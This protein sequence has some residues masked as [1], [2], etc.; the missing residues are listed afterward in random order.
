MATFRRLLGLVPI[1][2]HDVKHGGTALSKGASSSNFE[3]NEPRT[4][5]SEEQEATPTVGVCMID[6]FDQ[7]IL[8]SVVFWEPRQ[9]LMSNTKLCV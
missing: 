1:V 2:K 7:K 5:F 4:S 6:C 3:G 9:V 8:A